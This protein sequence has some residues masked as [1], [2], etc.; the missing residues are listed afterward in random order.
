M[1]THNLSTEFPHTPEEH[2]LLEVVEL[3]SVPLTLS[4]YITA[5]TSYSSTDIS[6]MEY[7]IEIQQ[8]QPPSNMI[9]QRRAL[10]ISTDRD[11]VEE[12]VRFM[13]FHTVTPLQLQYVLEDIWLDTDCPHVP[14]TI[15]TVEE[16]RLLNDA[17]RKKL[18]LLSQD[19]QKLQ[20]QELH[21]LSDN[22]HFSL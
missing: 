13:A 8:Q 15:L 17:Q 14:P 21:F 22:L 18:P 2:H 10:C 12:L 5:N 1:P 19:L 3:P 4:Y 6:M 7:G 9:Q 16:Q 20:Q 11:T